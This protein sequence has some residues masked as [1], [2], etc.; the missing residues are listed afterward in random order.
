VGSG[1]GGEV[2]PSSLVAWGRAPAFSLESSRSA[3]L[4]PAAREPALSGVEG[5]L[6]CS[7]TALGPGNLEQD[8]V[9]AAKGPTLELPVAEI[10]QEGLDRCATRAGAA[11]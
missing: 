8:L 4:S 7:D 3:A 1:E 6:A 2:K 5:D 10:P 9:A 11:A